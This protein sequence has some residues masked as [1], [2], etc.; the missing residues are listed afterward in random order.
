[1][2]YILIQFNDN[3]LMGMQNKPHG[4]FKKSRFKQIFAELAVVKLGKS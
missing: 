2:H 1:M 4:L 3:C